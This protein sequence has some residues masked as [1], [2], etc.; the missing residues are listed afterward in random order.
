MLLVACLLATAR[1]LSAEQGDAR[2]FFVDQS[3]SL[4]PSVAPRSLAT[5][6]IQSIATRAMGLEAADSKLTQDMLQSN[7]FKPARAFALVTV[8]GIGSSSLTDTKFLASLAGTAHSFELEGV[9]CPVHTA[10]SLLAMNTGDASLETQDT[11]P[12]I[13]DLLSAAFEGETNIVSVSGSAEEASAFSSLPRP[14]V[15]SPESSSSLPKSDHDLLNAIKAK[16]G[17]LSVLKASGIDAKSVDNKITIGVFDSSTQA[18]LALI[19]ELQ[20]ALSALQA[21]TEKTVNGPSFITMS[22]SSL[23]ALVRADKEK[24]EVARR[25]LDVTLAEIELRLQEAFPKSSMMTLAL[26]GSLSDKSETE[27]EARDAVSRRRLAAKASIS[28]ATT[29][30][31]GDKDRYQIVLWLSIL[32]VIATVWSIYAMAYMPFKKDADLYSTFNPNW[33][34]RKRQ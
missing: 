13:S 21:F 6:D 22:F 18:E 24:A 29:I 11:K 3:G 14:K 26:M 1:S 33:E 31:Q 8:D 2:V 9:G 23:K 20:G 5:T 15:E 10:P 25:M 7:F 32:A 27:S 19:V 34:H 12:G 30:T 28:T 4:R 16:E 17:L